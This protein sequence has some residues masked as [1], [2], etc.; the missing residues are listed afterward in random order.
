MLINLQHRYYIRY[1]SSSVRDPEPNLFGFV[2][3][4]ARWMIRKR[5]SI[6]IGIK[7]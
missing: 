3:F 5:S 7:I 2:L 1:L 6:Q 4:N